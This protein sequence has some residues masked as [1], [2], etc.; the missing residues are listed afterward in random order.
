MLRGL[1]LLILALAA[2]AA[3]A[4]APDLSGL[5]AAKLRFGPDV[6]GT[7]FLLQE[8]AGWRADVAGFSVPVRSAAGRL[9]FDLPDGKGS[10][11]GRREGALIRGQWIQERSVT[12]GLAYA[13]PV[14]LAADG[15]GRW[16]GEVVPRRDAFTYFLAL[17]REGAGYSA[18]LRN[19]ERNQGRFMRVA[20]VEP[21]GEELRFIARRGDSEATAAT[22]RWDAEAQTITAPLQRGTFVFTRDSS[23]SSAFYPRGK[24]GERYRYSAP[25]RLDDGWPVA[26]LASAGI[27]RPAIEAFVQKLI[28]TPMDS[29]GSS[30]VHSVLIARHGKLVLE[31][32]FHGYDRETV[33]DIRSAGKSM[34]SALIGAAIHAGV[35]IGEETPVYSTM[36]GT[37]PAD[38]DPRKRS[39]KLRHLMTMTGG[40]FCD[41]DNEEAPGNED[42]IA[43]QTEYRDLYGYILRLPMDRSPGE[44]LIYCSADAL[45][46][47]GVL[48][49]LAAEPLP[50]LFER[51]IARPLRMGPYHYN[52]TPA[53]EGYTAGGAHFRPRD[54]LKLP[55]L[56]LNDG[57]WGGR[58]I[59][60]PGWARKSAAPLFSLN[61]TQR[62]GYFWNSVDYSWQGK[63]VRAIFAAGNGGQIFMAIPELDLVVGFTGGSYA[64]PSALLVGRQFIPQEILPAVR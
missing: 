32:Y 50:D 9:E 36:L 8:G 23:Q 22:G 15:R 35:P 37:L 39:M 56:M 7:L 4:E 46:A 28:D 57:M 30:Q 64:D 51:L 17:K 19:P 38:L 25:L 13:T 44:K 62:Y 21:A 24:P 33:H 14:A 26:S 45:L 55:Q 40:H 59:L 18:F 53:G 61:P 20:R 3:A 34:T 41:D 10:F 16:R 47:G 1:P 2:P 29:L 6:A 42:R 27:S 58:R 11:R 52:L 5:W 63:T 54:F 60:E 49:K 48:R 43:E 31:E 12:G